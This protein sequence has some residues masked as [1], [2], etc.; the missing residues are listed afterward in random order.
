MLARK[1]QF[2]KVKRFCAFI[3]FGLGICLAIFLSLKW[4]QNPEWTKMQWLV[5]TFWVQVLSAVLISS[6]LFA[7]E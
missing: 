6:G 4:A 3:L 2:G 7:I 1:K 5:E